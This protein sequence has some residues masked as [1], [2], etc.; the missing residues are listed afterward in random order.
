MFK[1][2]NKENL[3]KSLLIGASSATLLGSLVTGTVH[4]VKAQGPD[5]DGDASITVDYDTGQILQGKD[6]DEPLGIASM[7][8][9]LV[10]YIVFEEIEEDKISWD[11]EITISEYAHQVS[12]DYSLSNVP[13]R[14]GDQYTLEELYEAMAI[15][16][17]NGATIAIAE[18][19]E[20]SEPDFV[21]RMRSTVESFGIDDAHIVNATGLNNSDLQGNTYPDTEEDDENMM[22]ARSVAKINDRIVRD[23]P[24]IL[25]IASIPE[26]TFREDTV[27]SIE[28]IN[29]NL[30][31]EG[32]SYEREGVDGLK[33]GTTNHAGP[34]FTG[35][36][37]Q[38]DRR[39]ITVV[40]NSGEDVEDLTTRFAETDKMMDYGFDDF[41]FENVTENWDEQLDYK[42]LPVENG[43]ADEVDYEPSE[44]L[45]MLIEKND[46]LE[47]DLTYSVEWDSDIVNEDGAVEAPLKEGMEVGYLVVEYSGNELGN[48]NGDEGSKVPIVTTESVDKAGVFGRSWNWI[49]DFFKSIFN[50]F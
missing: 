13:L 32:L 11:T 21:D 18:E 28:M 49:T 41:T 2:K 40:M 24:E 31:L 5:I 44:E 10:E 3:K 47:E 37:T 14:E 19:I 9:M 22:S 16:S 20:G 36:A 12:Q 34:T 26:K 1:Q 39:L 7:S 8:K 45:E 30:M 48:L 17:A 6:I 27:D 23:Y 46:D 33:T 25:D 4:P 15:Y 43:K 29:W 50:R 35:T 38:D 42:P